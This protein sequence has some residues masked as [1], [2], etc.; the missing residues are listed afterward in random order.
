MKPLHV[1]DLLHEEHAALQRGLRSVSAFTVRRC[2]ILLMSADERL[3]PRQIAQRLRY[4]DQCIRD[5]IRAFEEQGLDCLQEKSRA[6]CDDQS[7]FDATGVER[8]KEIIRLP[9]RTFGYET[10]LWTLKL[11]AEVC[12]KEGLTERLV[13]P[14]TVSRA[15]RRVGIAWRRAKHW[16]R[17]PDKYYAEKKSGAIG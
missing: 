8:L 4:S 6:R 2:Q 14:D 16:I 1:R 5:A 12:F 17:S 15:L 11:L 9:P 10:S 7:A 3:T 13:S